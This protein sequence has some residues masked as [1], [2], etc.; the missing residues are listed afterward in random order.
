MSSCP[1]E[2]PATPWRTLFQEVSKNGLEGT[3]R[4]GGP[5]YGVVM[6]P[7][8]PLTRRRA[9]GLIGAAG[10]AILAACSESSGP[11]AVMPN[12][13][14][15]ATTGTTAGAATAGAACETIPEETPGPFPGDG[16]N[17][18]DI[19]S[20]EGVVRRDIRTSI[21]SASATADGSP[22][23]FTL[24]ILDSSNGC[25]PYPGAA[26]YAWHCDRDG[27]YSMY[28]PATANENYL[29]GIQ[30]ADADG[31]ITFD[32]IFPGCYSGRWPHVHFEVFATLADATG[33]GE[34]IATSQLAF[35]ADSCAQAY[36]SAGYESSAS[37]LSRLSL[38]G[39]M[40]FADGAR[41]QTATMSGDVAAGFTAALDVTV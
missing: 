24:R 14:V 39:D 41:L 1:T 13:T 28:S 21:G 38:E 7:S 3:I 29:R 4:T 27:N 26:V 16:S 6:N 15:A 20:I 37:N 22:L 32:S 31:N 8:T 5:S 34:P 11:T 40:V 19:R 10:T 17:G 2:P 12:D 36:A 9:L 33:G 30:E 25:S 23:T 18:P 35:P